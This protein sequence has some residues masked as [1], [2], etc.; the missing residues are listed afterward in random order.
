ME[1][2]LK[3]LNRDK[4]P[5]LP[6]LRD[7]ATFMYTINHGFVLNAISDLFGC[8]ASRYSL[9]NSDYEIPLC[10][11]VQHPLGY[12]GTFT[13]SQFSCEEL[14]DFKSFKY[15]IKRV[16]LSSSEECYKT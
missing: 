1:S 11:I 15:N 10:E 5:T 4:L 7:I 16:Y 14:I 3:L 2:C 9:R 6:N 8:K 12:F 13:W